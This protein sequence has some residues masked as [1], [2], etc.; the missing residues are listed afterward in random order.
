MTDLKDLMV[1]ALSD[2]HGPGP[3]EPASAAGDLARGRRLLRRRRAAGLVGGTAVAAAAAGITA[4]AVSL[5]AAGPATG[6]P[7]PAAGPASR[8]VTAP[9]GRVTPTPVTPAI[10]LVA[11]GGSQVPGY[12]VAEV[13]S[14]WVLQGGNAFALVIAP[15]HDPDTNIGSFVGKLVVML[16]SA[17]EPVPASAP[18]QP[19]AGRPGYLRVQDDTQ[20]LIF[21]AANGAWVDIQA[22]VKL[23]WS[24]TE[25]AQ[26]A[27]GVQVLVNAQPG[28]G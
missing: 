20:I 26:F 1:L 27:A 24:G 16:K 9:A 23:G 2:G 5:A 12:R 18:R 10:A 7:A 11:Y 3:D 13:P 14:G 19:V 17:D 6:R 4:V 21:Q 22:P 8:A 25:L 28:R 15:A